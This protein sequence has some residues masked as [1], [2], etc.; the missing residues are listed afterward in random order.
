MANILKTFMKRIIYLE[1]Y[2][3]YLVL[4]RIIV[5]SVSSA[6]FNELKYFK[7]EAA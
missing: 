7:G 4:L 2:S 1:F 3:K 5:L 6:Y